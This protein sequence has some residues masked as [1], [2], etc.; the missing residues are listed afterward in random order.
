MV[1]VDG[2]RSSALEQAQDHRSPLQKSDADEIRQIFKPSSSSCRE[3]VGL[4]CVLVAVQQPNE[5]CRRLR[6]VQVHVRLCVLV[7]V[8]FETKPDS[9]ATASQEFA[10]AC[11]AC[12]PPTVYSNVLSNVCSQW[13]GIDCW[14]FV[15]RRGF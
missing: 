8:A 4:L 3:M 12:G 11:R 15:G 14:W 10:Q 2:K 6:M 5:K 13:R 1:D 9:D 7:P